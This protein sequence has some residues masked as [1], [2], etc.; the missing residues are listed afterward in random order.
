MDSAPTLS[1]QMRSLPWQLTDEVIQIR[2]WGGS[3]AY[4]LPDAPSGRWH[5][6][7]SSQCEIR[8]V[9]ELRQVSRLHACISRDHGS[10]TMSDLK[11]KNGLWVD[12]AR[13]DSCALV[14]GVEVG[15]G[16][17]RL[18]AESARL[19]TLRRYLAQVLGWSPSA[20]V[21]VDLAIRCVRALALHRRPLLLHG[22]GDLVPIAQEIHR[23]VFGAERPFVVNDPHH[24]GPSHGKRRIRIADPSDAI[25]A[26]EGGTLCVSSDR[27]SAARAELES[28]LAQAHDV[29]LM[30]WGS[31]PERLSE[32]V[33]RIAIPPLAARREEFDRLTDALAADALRALGAAASSYDADVRNEV[34][35]RA[36]ADLAAME[37]TVTRLIAMQEW[38]SVT[39]AA[40]KLG[41]SHVALSR[42]LRR[43]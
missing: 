39:R 12:N 20:V 11:S 42:W 7:T 27:T 23:L 1:A 29:R 10:L 25:A 30:V 43:A 15:L 26:A 24:Q 32:P 6:G 33:R 41:I 4:A 21:R 31:K 37:R 13:I 8:I 9:D 34:R 17:V 40:A 35:R 36:P 14:S 38:P 5:I 3:R 22:A 19:I 28:R 16:P 2:E 18:I